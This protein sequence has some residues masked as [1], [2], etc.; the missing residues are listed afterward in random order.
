MRS[1]SFDGLPGSKT[2]GIKKLGEQYTINRIASKFNPDTLYDIKS[3]NFKSNGS[4]SILKKD[5]SHNI[6]AK[7]SS[8]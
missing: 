2:N 5:D 4:I 1:G 6:H 7:L 8:I 3:L